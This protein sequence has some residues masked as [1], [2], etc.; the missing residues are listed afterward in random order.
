MKKKYN[1]LTAIAMVVGIVIGSG[2]FFKV[3]NILSITNGNIWTGIFA[4]LAGGVIM[5]VCATAFANLATR[6]TK[7]NG[8][9]DYSDAVVGEKYG[10]LMAWFIAVVYYPAMTSVL[11]WVTAR[12]TGVLFGWEMTSANVMTLGI[13]YMIGIFAV[14]TFSPI[15]A[16]KLQ[17]STTIIKL[18]PLFLMGF[19][20]LI[21]GLVNNVIEYQYINGEIVKTGK[22]SLQVLIENFSKTGNFIFKDF[23]GAL[24]AAAFA[25]E[26]W[27][28]ATAISE[29]LKDAKKNLPIALLCG[30]AI[31]MA[32]YILY[33]LG[34]SGGATTDVLLHG[35][36]Q[37]A[38]LEI[39]GSFFGT[40]LNVF[41]VISCIGTLNGLMVA[42]TRAF[43]TI[44]KRKVSKRF[45]MFKNVDAHTNMPMSSAALGLLLVALWHLFF[46][47]AN[48]APEKWFGSFSFDSSELPIVTMYAMYF[49]I[50]ILVIVKERKSMGIF[51]GIILPIL[52][53]ICSG[54]MVFAAIYSHGIAVLYYVILYVVIMFI[55]IV[56]MYY[57]KPNETVLE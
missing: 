53:T 4:L 57:K 13:I 30:T 8:I 56:L 2:V 38:F 19:V 41:V 24:V 5:I 1:L 36:A 10:S 52:A 23:L 25:Y 47:G 21:F 3:Q 37:Y 42:T 20:G 48:L 32:V 12:Y 29:E 9:V 46:Y 40:L 45:E 16:G 33:Y 17:I 44:S 15:L 11:V 27:M 31:I 54:F 26:G 7:I 18:I 50:F 35:G 22:D 49:P 14:N 39:F 55:G 34:V 28:V 51:K 6:Y 43:Y